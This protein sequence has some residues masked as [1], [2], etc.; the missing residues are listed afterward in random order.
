[1]ARTNRELAYLTTRAKF[2]AFGE[3]TFVVVDVI[4]PAMLGPARV[5]Q[6]SRLCLYLRGL[7]T[8]WFMF[9]KRA[10]KPEGASEHRPRRSQGTW[11]LGGSMDAAVTYPLEKG[12]VVRLK[13]AIPGHCSGGNRTYLSRT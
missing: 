3:N 1:M 7:W 9:G 13:E 8:Y 4:L 11:M 6:R 10:S 5:V 12:S 2:F